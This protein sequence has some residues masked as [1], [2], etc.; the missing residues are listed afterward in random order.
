MLHFVLITSVLLCLVCVRISLSQQTTELLS[1]L[2]PHWTKWHGNQH[3][4]IFLTTRKKFSLYQW[5]HLMLMRWGESILKNDEIWLKLNDPHY[6]L[7]YQ[8]VPDTH[9]YK[10][11]QTHIRGAFYHRCK[12]WYAQHRSLHRTSAAHARLSFHLH[13]FM[14]T[15]EPCDLHVNHDE[16]THMHTKLR[17]YT[18]AKKNWV[19]F[20]CF[21]FIHFLLFVH[22]WTQTYLQRYKPASV[23]RCHKRRHQHSSAC[24][25]HQVFIQYI[26]SLEKKK[27]KK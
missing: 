7:S 13:Q 21:S 1:V 5:Q 23:V 3:V 27:R 2:P 19:Q 4:L 9:E 15:T 10:F 18:T 22:L 6:G 20:V 12:Q 14:S 26:L 24:L 8:E 11:V 16:H 25:Y 17:Y